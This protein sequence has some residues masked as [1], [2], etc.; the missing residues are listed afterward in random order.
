[1]F[2]IRLRITRKWTLLLVFL[3]AGLNLWFKTLIMMVEMSLSL[4]R[5]IMARV[6]CVFGLGAETP[7]GSA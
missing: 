6:K 1:M 4:F 2:M 5:A 3:I 7:Q